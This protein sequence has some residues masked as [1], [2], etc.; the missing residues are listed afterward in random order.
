MINLHRFFIS[1]LLILIG[2]STCYSQGDSLRVF[3]YV[4]DQESRDPLPGAYI[5][6]KESS[7]ATMTDVDGYFEF[8]YR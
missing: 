7:L 4:Y 3:G 8:L 6:V 5:S 1:V 2:F